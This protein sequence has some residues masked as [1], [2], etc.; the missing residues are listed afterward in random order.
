MVTKVL[1]NYHKIESRA[2]CFSGHSKPG[3][4]LSNAGRHVT[5][6]SES[7]PSKLPARFLTWE[8]ELTRLRHFTGP[9][10]VTGAHTFPSHP[11]QAGC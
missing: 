3:M 2:E 1:N 6:C 8:S 4:P 11:L 7:L 9:P 5:K 10:V